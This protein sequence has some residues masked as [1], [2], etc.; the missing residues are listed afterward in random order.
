MFLAPACDLNKVSCHVNVHTYVRIQ[1]HRF[2]TYI[3]DSRHLCYGW[4]K[5]VNTRH[6]LTSITWPCRGLRLKVHLGHF[7]LIRLMTRYWIIHVM[8]FSRDFREERHLAHH[9]SQTGLLFLSLV[10]LV[11]HNWWT[12]FFSLLVVYPGVFWTRFVQEFTEVL[13]LSL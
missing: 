5:A 11:Y 6:P 3:F 12:V 4:L 8:I 7:F 10:L 9:S 1:Y 13:H 2:H